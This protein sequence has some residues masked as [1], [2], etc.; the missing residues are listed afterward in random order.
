[1]ISRGTVNSVFGG[2]ARVVRENI[3]EKEASKLK[4]K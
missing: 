2:E 1:M 4:P 3:L